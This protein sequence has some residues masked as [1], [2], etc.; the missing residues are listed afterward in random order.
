MTADRVALVTRVSERLD[1]QL[2]SVSDIAEWVRRCPEFQTELAAVAEWRVEV[3]RQVQVPQ[4]DY[5]DPAGSHRY[6]LLSG[7]LHKAERRAMPVGEQAIDLAALAVRDAESASWYPGWASVN[8][9]VD[10]ARDG[11]W[12]TLALEEAVRIVGELRSGPEV[13]VARQ[14]ARALLEAAIEAIA[15]EAAPAP[16][17][18]L[19][20][21]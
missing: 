2:A 11:G 12:D 16:M 3:L 5:G 18:R 6:T 1:R 21:G 9:L 19:V 15:G 17:L 4:P 10:R 8:V 13:K 14:T 7:A 20:D